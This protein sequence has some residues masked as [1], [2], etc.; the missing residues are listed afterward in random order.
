MTNSTSSREPG[1]GRAR[2][3]DDRVGLAFHKNHTADA[4]HGHRPP[5]HDNR[6]VTSLET[7][8]AGGCWCG[9]PLHDWPGSNLGAPHPPDRPLPPLDYNLPPPPPDISELVYRVI[10]TR[11]ELLDRIAAR[12]I[13]ARCG[14]LMTTVFDLERGTVQSTVQLMPDWPLGRFEEKM[15]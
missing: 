2:Y 14:I 7:I 9:K 6:L 11:R 1:G 10:D 4:Q 15:V 13:A 5:G 3:H 8:S 12:A